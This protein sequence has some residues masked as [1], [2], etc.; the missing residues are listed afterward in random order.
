[1]WVRF[2][3]AGPIHTKGSTVATK[4]QT[5]AA[6]QLAEFLASGG[7]VQE[8]PRGKSGYAEGES[9]SVWGA[10]KKRAAAEKTAGKKAK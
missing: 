2:L 8:I 5:E 1:M 6:E 7:K 4:Q 9:R 3:H 10:P